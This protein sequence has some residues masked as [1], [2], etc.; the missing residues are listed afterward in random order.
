MKE[1]C[2]QSKII[3][4]RI[5]SISALLTK[6]T[7][8]LRIRLLFYYRNWNEVPKMEIGMFLVSENY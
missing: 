6:A 8:R 4:K 2:K 7:L 5:G 1:A 3:E